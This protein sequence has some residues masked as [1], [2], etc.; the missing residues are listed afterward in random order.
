MC[1][2]RSYSPLALL[3]NRSFETLTE[4]LKQYPH[5]QVVSRDGFTGFRQ[6]ISDANSSILQVYDR[7][8][9]IQNAK[10]HLDT[11]LLSAVPST[12][13]WCKTPPTPIEL[14]L[15]KAEKVKLARQKQKWDLI[16]EIQEAYRLGKSIC[17]LAKEYKLN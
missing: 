1:D 14:K 17:S 15:T 6:A 9:F 8:H 4:W 3:P 16:Q 11:F 10:K 12:I 13:T 7:W 5:I 2:L